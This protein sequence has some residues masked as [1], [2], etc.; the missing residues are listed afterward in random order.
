MRVHG[1]AMADIDLWELHEAF[2]VTTLYN[3][4]QLETPWE[5]TNVNGGAIALGHPYG[6]SGIRYLGSTLLELE[7]CNARRA[8]M[9]VCAAGGQAT[10]AYLER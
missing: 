10:A 8:I 3:Q 5:R 6:M 4:S 2:A 1:L 9:G 7:R